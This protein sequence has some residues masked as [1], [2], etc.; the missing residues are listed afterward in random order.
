M[1]V[2]IDV[3]LR[4]KAVQIAYPASI[5]SACGIACE[6]S[7]GVAVGKHNFTTFEGGPD[8]M[9]RAVHVIGAEEQAVGQWLERRSGAS[10]CQ[11]IRDERRS[12]PRGRGDV[13]ALSNKPVLQ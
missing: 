13:I 7:I 1:Q 12:S 9:L 6:S 11:D 8:D 3:E 4:G 2:N 5:Q 10:A